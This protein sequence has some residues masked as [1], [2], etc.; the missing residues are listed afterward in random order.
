[1][2][3]S[4]WCSRE[5]ER[6]HQRQ[7][8]VPQCP[9]PRRRCGLNSRRSRAPAARTPPDSATG[10]TSWRRTDRRAPGSARCRP[11][12]PVSA[13]SR[14]VVTVSLLPDEARNAPESRHPDA[15][16][17]IAALSN[18]RRLDRAAQREDVA[19]V[20]IARPVVEVEPPHRLGFVRRVEDRHRHHVPAGDVGGAAAA[21]RMAL[22]LR[23]RV[24]GADAHPVGRAALN[25]QQ[26]PVVLLRPGVGEVVEE[27]DEPAD[28]RIRAA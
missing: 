20:L 2:R 5:A 28:R 14:P 19:P 11:G 15:S 23:Q 13:R 17:R 3:A 6:P 12:L 16:I 1:M 21:R 4:I 27:P 25:L 18:S 7:V 26:Q 24:V 8:D 22:A 9:A 10:S